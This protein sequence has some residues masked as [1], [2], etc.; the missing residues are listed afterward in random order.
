MVSVSKN[1]SA[2]LADPAGA[3][4]RELQTS[5]VRQRRSLETQARGDHLS[6]GRTRQA[7]GAGG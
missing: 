2:V 6:R 3:P 1:I 5:S 4:H 7:G